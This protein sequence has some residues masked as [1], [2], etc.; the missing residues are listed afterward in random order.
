M[1][2]PK[3]TLELA[4]EVLE[5]KN[6]YDVIYEQSDDIVRLGFAM[7]LFV[8]GDDKNGDAVKKHLGDAYLAV[9]SMMLYF[10]VDPDKTFKELIEKHKN[11]LQ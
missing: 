8:S 1:K 4:V 7:K 5:S 9:M 6:T 3:D 2:K 10:E 11:I